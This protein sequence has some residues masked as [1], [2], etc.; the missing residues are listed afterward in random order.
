MESFKLT[1]RPRE[2]TEEDALLAATQSQQ[3]VDVAAANPSD[4]LRSEAD[5]EPGSL[6]PLGS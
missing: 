6:S 3:C 2:Q 4:F 5:E 1:V